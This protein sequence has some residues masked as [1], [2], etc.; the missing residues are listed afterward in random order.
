MWLVGVEY[1][2]CRTMTCKICIILLVTI[3]ISRECMDIGSDICNMTL[4]ELQTQKSA[5]VNF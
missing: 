2:T 3:L 1:Y 4:A 5:Y